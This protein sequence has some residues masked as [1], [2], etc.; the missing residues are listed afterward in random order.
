M[1]ILF[2]GDIVGKIGRRIVKERVPYYVEKYGVDFVIA[3]GENATHG[4]GL[5]YNHYVE[6]INDGID[7]ITLGNH[8]RSKKEIY[9]YIDHV[10]HL[11]RPLNVIDS[12]LGGVGSEVFSV[13]GINIRVTSIIGSSFINDVTV[14]NPYLSLKEV[15]DSEEEK[16]DIH[17]VDFHGEATGEKIGFGF[18][19]DGQVS[20]VLGTHTHVQT[21]DAHILP[22]GT[23]FICDVG[24]CG[25]ADGILGCETSSVNLKTIFGQNTHFVYPDEGR[26]L[27]SAVVLDIDNK[28]GKCTDIFPILYTE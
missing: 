3:N 14:N 24:M 5:N 6:L 21:R 7:V 17:I 4:K 22:E 1:K 16:A 8:Y 25:Y 27:F 20:A 23:G 13:D 2:I 18:A 9:S 12:E 10:D 26:G 28:T 11:I 15:I 19:F